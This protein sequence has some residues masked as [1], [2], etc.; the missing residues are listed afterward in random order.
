LKIEGPPSAGS[1]FKKTERASFAKLAT[2]ASID[3]PGNRWLKTAPTIQK[4]PLKDYQAYFL[5]KLFV[6]R[7][8][9]VL[10]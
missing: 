6:F 9:A 5:I 8:A 4:Q 3:Y 10:V 1:I 7:P 2:Q